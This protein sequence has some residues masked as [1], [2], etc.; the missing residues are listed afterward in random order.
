MSK[1]LKITLFLI[2]LLQILRGQNDY[3]NL[4][5]NPSFEQRVLTVAPHTVDMIDSIEEFVGWT[6]PTRIRAMVYTTLKTGFVVDIAPG[7]RDYKAKTGKNVAAIDPFGF[8]YQV[9]LTKSEEKRSYLEGELTQPLVVGQK[10]YVGFSIHYHCLAT[11]N[12]G[13]AFAFRENVKDTSPRLRLT[14]VAIQKIGVD[15]NSNNIWQFIV[16][17][18][19]ADQAYKNCYIGNF[20]RNDSTV[21]NGSLLFDHYVAYIDDV[22]VLKAKN[23]LMPPK[24]VVIKPI[25]PLPKVL[26]RVQFK[27]NSTDF[28]PSSFPQ[29]DSAA[30]TL[31]NFPK[32]QILIKGHTSSEGSS[33]HNQRLSERRAEAVK[34]YLINKGI[35]ANR[36]Q[37]KGFGST[38]PI[39]TET[40]EENRRLNRRIEFEIIAE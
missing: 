13:I 32:L 23:A 19:V 37:T 9:G 3:Q 20:F 6:S 14:P 33:E 28:E 29:L 34:N 15:Y 25:S 11:N 4:V 35:N 17:S 40:T 30:L 27:V 38:E 12:I 18:F 31:S 7:E 22:F 2:F 21:I 26:N 24:K 36:L 5:V 10:Y 8:R 39:A 16:D 1:S